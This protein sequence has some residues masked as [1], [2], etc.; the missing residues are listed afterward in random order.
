M[1]PKD[2][3][4]AAMLFPQAFEGWGGDKLWEIFL[5]KECL[6]MIFHMSFHFLIYHIVIST[7]VIFLK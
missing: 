6:G 4:L 1:V 5:T 3:L 2:I 7:N